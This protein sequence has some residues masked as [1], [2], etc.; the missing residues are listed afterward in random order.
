[1]EDTV[2]YLSLGNIL[3]PPML[4]LDASTHILVMATYACAKDH[5][6]WTI[7]LTHHC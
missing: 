3:A 2:R 5:H 4:I 6:L 7:S 1:M